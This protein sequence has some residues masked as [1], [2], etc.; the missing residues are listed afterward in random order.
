MAYH[1]T[2]Q[3]AHIYATRISSASTKDFARV[4]NTSLRLNLIWN[5]NTVFNKIMTR[6]H[7]FVSWTAC[8]QNN[9][10]KRFWSFSNIHKDSRTHKLSHESFAELTHRIQSEFIRYYFTRNIHKLLFSAMC[11]RNFNLTVRCLTY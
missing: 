2:E 5:K 1:C 10:N 11:V 4:V 8:K 3:W 7:I 9:A 6:T